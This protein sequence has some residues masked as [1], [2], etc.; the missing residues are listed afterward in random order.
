MALHQGKWRPS[1]QPLEGYCFRHQVE[2]WKLPRNDLNWGDMPR[3]PAKRER[4]KLRKP[5]FGITKTNIRRLWR[6][7]P[8]LTDITTW[9]RHGF[10]QV[11]RTRLWIRCEVKI[12]VQ[13]IATSRCYL[14]K[15]LELRAESKPTSEDECVSALYEEVTAIINGR[16]KR[17][18]Y[19]KETWARR[20]THR[21]QH[22]QGVA[23]ESL[24]GDIGLQL[25]RSKE[26]GGRRASANTWQE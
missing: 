14:S 1:V 4:F 2:R 17:S 22:K 5:E 3:I 18:D 15:A 23:S 11:R 6:A 21:C 25:H 16:C 13:P 7:S 12:C 24:T 10:Q 19:G 20:W 8:V 9:N 26:L